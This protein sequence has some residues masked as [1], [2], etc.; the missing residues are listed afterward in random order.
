PQA[1]EDAAGRDDGLL[2][3]H[4]QLPQAGAVRMAG[5]AGEGEPGHL[6]D[7]RSGDPGR[8]LDRLAVHALDPG[9]A[10]L[11]LHQPVAAGDRG[12]APVGRI[13]RLNV[14][15]VRTMPDTLPPAP[16]CVKAGAPAATVV[17]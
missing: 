5:P 15:G 17:R 16:A 9:E 10:V 7:P 1:V 3:H 11:H 6:P 2:L 12:Q 14:A 8:L 4:R 13:D